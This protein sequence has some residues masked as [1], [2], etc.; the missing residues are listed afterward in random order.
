MHLLCGCEDCRQA[1]QWAHTKGGAMPVDLPRVYYLPSDIL[2]VI[3]QDQMILVKLRADGVSE[4]IFCRNCYSIIAIDHPD[5]GDSVLMIFEGYCMTD[6]DLSAPLSMMLYMHDYPESAGPVPD[7]KV[8]VFQSLRFPQEQERMMAIKAASDT[9][10]PRS[11]PPI[12]ITLRTLIAR[13]G[14]PLVL[15]LEKG[16]SLQP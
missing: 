3:G 12:G 6:A 9:W 13:L 10:R 1:L 7:E 15:N 16:M 4:R 5:Y 14:P 8:P 11:E 2:E